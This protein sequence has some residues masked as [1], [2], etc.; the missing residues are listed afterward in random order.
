MKP[1]YFKSCQTEAQ[2]QGALRKGS[3]EYRQTFTALSKACETLEIKQCGKQWDD[4]HVSQLPMVAS[5]RQQEALLNIRRNGE[6]RDKTKECEQRQECA[7]KLKLH[8]VSNAAHKESHPE[9]VNPIFTNMGELI[10]R[11]FRVANSPIEL[12]RLENEWKHIL[13]QVQELKQMMPI[14]DMSLF[15]T[16]PDSFYDAL[17]MACI[18]AM[19]TS[20]RILLFDKTVHFM[21]VEACNSLTEVLCMLK[22]IYHEHHIGQSFEAVCDTLISSLKE[23]DRL[24]E[25]AGQIENMKLVFFTHFRDSDI[26]TIV[27]SIE[28]KF[29]ENGW[30][31]PFLLFWRGHQEKEGPTAFL[32]P[33]KRTIFFSGNTNY[34]WTRISNMPEEAWKHLTAFDFITVILSHPRYSMFELV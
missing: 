20:K 32:F 7:A 25:G 16:N 27:E 3:K 4:I 13:S 30:V 14:L 10:K 31:R 33:L 22:P 18:V 34:I 12:V 11:A 1:E 28:K 17:G 8:W 29:T 19:K 15:Y 6:N 2:F 23:V 24:S 5:R 21:N 26:K 9:D